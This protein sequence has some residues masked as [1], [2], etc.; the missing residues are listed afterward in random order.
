MIMYIL[1]N[2]CLSPLP[3]PPWRYLGY[4]CVVHVWV[5]GDD[6][7]PLQLRPHHERVHRPLDVVG[8]VL[9]GLERRRWEG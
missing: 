1:Y 3:L 9:L 2:F 7:P 8:G 4:L 6:L 5:P